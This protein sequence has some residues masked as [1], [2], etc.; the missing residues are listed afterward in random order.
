MKKIKISAIMLSVFT[1]FGLVILLIDIISSSIFGFYK[2]ATININGTEYF[3]ATKSGNYLDLI[4][5]TSILLITTI[6]FWGIYIIKN[7]NKQ[8]R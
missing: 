2:N 1:V 3:I 4:I 5:L 6:V 8:R 7:K